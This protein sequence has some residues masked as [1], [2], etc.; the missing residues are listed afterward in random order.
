MT[1]PSPAGLA[2]PPGIRLA[3][4]LNELLGKVPVP[5]LW[6]TVTLAGNL[7][8]RERLNTKGTAARRP[9]YEAGLIAAKHDGPPPQAKTVADGDPD[10]AAL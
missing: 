3:A 4:A 5:H 10:V 8:Y 9:G 2:R 1:S 6:N 7:R